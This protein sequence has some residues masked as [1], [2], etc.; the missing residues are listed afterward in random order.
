MDTMSKLIGALEPLGRGV[1]RAFGAVGKLTWQ[2]DGWLWANPS[3]VATLRAM[4]PRY[5]TDRLYIGG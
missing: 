2:F 5:A 1:G 4:P 3:V